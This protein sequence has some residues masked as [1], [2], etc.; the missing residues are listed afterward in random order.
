MIQQFKFHKEAQT[1]VV[2]SEL[3]MVRCY[4]CVLESLPGSQLVLYP[5]FYSFVATETKLEELG[6][7]CR[8]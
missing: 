6:F 5:F 8:P 7:G 1:E 4:V 3:I 2:S